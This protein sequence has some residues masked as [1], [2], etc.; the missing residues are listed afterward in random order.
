M[1]A[2]VEAI[3]NDFHSKLRSFTLRRVS[4]A[5]AADDI[6]QDV[7]LRIHSHIDDLRAQDRLEG[8]IFQIARNAIIDYYRRTR[9]QEELPETVAAPK[10]EEPDTASEVAASLGDMVR[11]LP[12]KYR[13]ALE[14][15]EFQGLSQVE[16]AAKLNISASGAKS[17][18]QRARQKLKDALLDC[19]HY[20]FDRYGRIIDYHANCR[21]CAGEHAPG[22][23][24]GDEED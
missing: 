19:C 14:L 22:N 15:T 24:G 16:L 2:T 20:E 5:D 23:C 12:R 7:Y 11:C 3:Y 4:D 13:Q 21:E 8:W 10:E 6:L 17:R 18:V 9:P 1:E